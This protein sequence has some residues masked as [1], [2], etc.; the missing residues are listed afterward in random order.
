[1][2]YLRG[3]KTGLCP[4]PLRILAQK[5][6]LDLTVLYD[7]TTTFGIKKEDLGSKGGCD[8]VLS[9]PQDLKVWGGADG[10]FFRVEASKEDADGGL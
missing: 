7:Y 6:P 9:P 5:V 10:G 3:G 4:P 1:M 2:A 8:S